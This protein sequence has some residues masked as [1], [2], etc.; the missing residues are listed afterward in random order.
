MDE[1][2]SLVVVGSSHRGAL[3]RVLPGSVGERLLHGSPCPVAVAP[4]GYEPPSLGEAGTVGAAFDERPES[5]AALAEAARWTRALGARLR[6]ITVV[7][8]ADPG[9]PELD[10]H[11]YQTRLRH[12]HD[13]R[14]A[15]LAKALA[16]H[17]AGLGDKG[18]ACSRARRSTTW[19]SSRASS[20][21]SSWARAGTDRCAACSSAACRARCSRP[22][23][24]RSWWCRAGRASAEPRRVAPI[25]SRRRVDRD[26]GETDPRRL[27]RLIEIG[28]SLVTELDP[29]PSFSACSM[30]RAS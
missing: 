20:I 17:P 18:A 30:W 21:C 5:L 25:V 7:E 19:R 14:E 15:A 28:R 13:L 26:L 2:A 11:S 3:G 23:P 10:L 22:P 6:A 9:H 16:V 27:E 29:E 4:R 8:A 12:A 1:A 24:A